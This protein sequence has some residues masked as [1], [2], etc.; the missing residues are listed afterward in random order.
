MQNII[1]ELLLFVA[2]KGFFFCLGLAL[3]IAAFFNSS[4]IVGCLMFGVGLISVLHAI[5]DGDIL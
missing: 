4:L 1:E 3:M 2:K 5:S